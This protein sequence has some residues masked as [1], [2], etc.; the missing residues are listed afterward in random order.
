MSQSIIETENVSVNLQN[1]KETSDSE[2]GEKTDK[3]S[4]VLVKGIFNRQ[5]SVN[6]RNT[7]WKPTPPVRR[8]SISSIKSNSS[9]RS[10]HVA[11]PPG[12][13][14]TKSPTD[15]QAHLE[16]QFIEISNILKDCHI[17]ETI[18]LKIRN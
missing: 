12:S 6:Y 15:Q 3:S 9:S 11:S 10:V 8:G 4:E 17:D 13:P 16:S 2:V 5:G 1:T 14:I 7:G 18:L